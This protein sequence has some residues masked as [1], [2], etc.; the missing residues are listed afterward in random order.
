MFPNFS[1]PSHILA[2]NW[3]RE[4]QSKLIFNKL[5]AKSINFNFKLTPVNLKASKF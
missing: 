2:L 4:L 5:K 1:H 3:L